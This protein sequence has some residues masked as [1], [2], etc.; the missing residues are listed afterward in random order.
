[1]RVPRLCRL[2]AWFGIACCLDPIRFGSDS[3]LF[4]YAKRIKHFPSSSR[5]SS[6]LF[7]AYPER[8]AARGLRVFCDA[9]DLNFRDRSDAEPSSIL[10]R[11]ESILFFAKLLK[12][13]QN[14]NM[15]LCLR[16]GDEEFSMIARPILRKD[17]G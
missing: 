1:M 10:R 4:P 11:Q 13:K 2:A 14:Q 9:G 3:L 16:R 8:V 6:L 15:D 12:A 7:I 17:P 5:G